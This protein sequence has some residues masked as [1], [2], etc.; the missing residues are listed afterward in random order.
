MTDADLEARLAPLAAAAEAALAGAEPSH[1]FLHV[2]RVTA[3][4]RRIATAEGADLAV[5]LPAALLHELFSYPK[6]DPRSKL[7]GEACAE[8]AAALLAA[9]RWEPAPIDAIAYAIRVHPYSLGIRPETLEGRVLQDADRLDAIGAIGIARLFASTAVMRRPFYHPD[10]PLCRSG[11]AP[12][13]KLWGVDH[14][15]KKLLRVP[16]GLHTRS[17][18]VMASDRVRC[19]E[20]F[21]EHLGREIEG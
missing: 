17:A 15:Y 3:N 5:V 11:R 13:D 20:A 16:E 18:R 4:A 2:R 21:L 9:E 19:M 1:D 6:S 12:D 10:D 7:S 14:F 8:R